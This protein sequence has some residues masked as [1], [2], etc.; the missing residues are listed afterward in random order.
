MS[1]RLTLSNGRGFGICWDLLEG[2]SG[3]FSGLDIIL[4][5]RHDGYNT[6]SK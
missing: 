6:S 1:R 5:M 3:R 2:I 4:L